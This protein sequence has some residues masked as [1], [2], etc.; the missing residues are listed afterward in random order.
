MLLS[1]LAQSLGMTLQGEDWEFTGL[2]T[3]ESANDHEVSFLANPKYRQQLAATKACAV[4][5][6]PEFASEVQRALV[7]DNPYFDFAR[8]GMFFLRKESD[9]TGISDLAVIHPQ[10]LLGK[11]CIIH[12]HAHIGA[13]ARLGEGCQLYP[14]AYVG[15]DCILGKNC[16][17]YPNAVVL[18]GVEMGDNC[19]LRP[20][21]VVGSDGFGFVRIGGEMQAIPQ[22]GTVCLANGVDVGANSCVDR[23][24]LGA[25]RVGNDSKLD[26][27]V[28]IGHNVS[29]GEQCLVISQVGIAGSTK[30]GDRVTLA[31]QAGIA[32]HLLIGDDVIVGPQAGVAKSIEPGVSGSGSPFMQGRTYMRTSV[33]IPKLP[34]IY[35]RVQ[36]MEKELADLKALLAGKDSKVKQ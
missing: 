4:I 1:E 8:A 13:R 3:L 17:L 19:V 25:T 6:A 35:K 5:V 20:G 10:A 26:N 2:N 33:L 15:D 28:Q 32:G 21:A 12:P 36:D 30:V 7:S 34:E 24:T 11:D 27:L 23:A 18:A 14:G 9:F 16:I 29:L 22:I 31:G